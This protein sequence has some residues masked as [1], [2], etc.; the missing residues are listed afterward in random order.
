MGNGREPESLLLDA[1]NPPAP[2]APE[3]GPDPEAGEKAEARPG[4]AADG[5]PCIRLPGG[6]QGDRADDPVRL[7]AEQALERPRGLGRSRM[8]GKVEHGEVEPGR[9]LIGQH[10]IPVEAAVDRGCL[11]LREVANVVDGSGAPPRPGQGFAGDAEIRRPAG[12]PGMPDESAL[13]P[14]HEGE[15]RIEAR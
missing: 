14:Q 10:R 1:E 5:I 15:G 4:Q 9:K 6:L 7:H 11:L 12:I 3:D 8:N 2:A 13:V